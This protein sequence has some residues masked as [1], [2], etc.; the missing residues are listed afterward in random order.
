LSEPWR[1]CSPARE[2]VRCAPGSH[3][4]AGKRGFT[5]LSTLLQMLP[6]TRSCQSRCVDNRGG[7]TWK[8]G[9]RWIRHSYYWRRWGGCF[10]AWPPRFYG[11]FWSA[12]WS[13]QEPGGPWRARA[14][15]VLPAGPNYAPFLVLSASEVPSPLPAPQLRRST[16]ESFSG[17]FRDDSAIFSDA[18]A[19]VFARTDGRFR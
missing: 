6:Y 8:G 14:R 4:A 9:A 1:R 10:S 16:K 13:G 12:S 5:T 7:W 19:V 3:D 17:K 11:S 2:R 18:G 15:W